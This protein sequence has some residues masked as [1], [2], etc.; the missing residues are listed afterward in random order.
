MMKMIEA[1][2]KTNNAIGRWF[3]ARLEARIDRLW[4]G[5][6]LLVNVVVGLLLDAKYIGLFLI[7]YCFFF[8]LYFRRQIKAAYPA[9][10][11]VEYHIGYEFNWPNWSFNKSF[12]FGLLFI[13]VLMIPAVLFFVFVPEQ[14][15]VTGVTLLLVVVCNAFLLFRYRALFTTCCGGGK[16][17][18]R[19]EKR[20][21]RKMGQRSNGTFPSSRLIRAT[22]IFALAWG[23]LLAAYVTGQI[24]GKHFFGADESVAL[25]SPSAILFVPILLHLIFFETLTTVL[26]GWG[27]Q[28]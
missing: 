17:A 10:T 21:Q 4:L 25:H 3:A 23:G 16:L 8:V 2:V 13:Y 22:V 28:R 15:A 24:G 7:A 9:K 1:L 19:S 20:L 18:A 27:E 12:W 6:V 11:N 5:G 26:R 14:Y